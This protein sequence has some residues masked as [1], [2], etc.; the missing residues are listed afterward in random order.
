MRGALLV[1][2]RR[3]LA[4]IA[5]LG[6]AF[7]GTLLLWTTVRSAL[8]LTAQG[9]V[10][11][12]A[13]LWQRLQED[14]TTQTGEVIWVRAAVEPCASWET[15]IMA[16]RCSAR[17]PVLTDPTQRI[18]G[19]YLPFV[20]RRETSLLAALRRLP[21]A[22]YLLPSTS[23]QWE[24]PATYRVRLLALPSD[25]CDYPVCYGATVLDVEP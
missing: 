3:H 25:A 23:W 10:H 19:Q 13:T 1:E 14:R 2:G 24:V 17:E 18:L 7:L 22:H 5:L 9:H 21:F 8:A 12:M 15:P 4:F 6:A 16:F 11:T 20:V